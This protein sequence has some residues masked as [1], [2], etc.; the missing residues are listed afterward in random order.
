MTLQSMPVPKEISEPSLASVLDRIVRDPSVPLERM[1]QVLNML[2]SRED[3]DQQRHAKQSYAEAMAA[4]QEEMSTISTDSGN[5]QTRSRYASL[6][7][8]DRAI[9]PIYTK[10]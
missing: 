6:A 10:H 8:I 7:A 1:Q 9:R 2:D 5:P 4:A 3:R